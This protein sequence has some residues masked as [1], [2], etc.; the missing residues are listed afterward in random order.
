MNLKKGGKEPGATT[1]TP[2][3]FLCLLIPAVL[4]KQVLFLLRFLRISGSS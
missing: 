1:V 4:Q 3:R 2:G